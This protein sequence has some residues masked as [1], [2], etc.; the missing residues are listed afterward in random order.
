MIK[1]IIFVALSAGLIALANAQPRPLPFGNYF[2]SCFRVE[3]I[4]PTSITAYCQKISRKLDDPGKFVYSVLEVL[5]N[6]Q[7][8]E[9][10]EN[11]DGALT[12]TGG[13]GF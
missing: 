6:G 1:R 5:K 8:C 2:D 9:Y 10:V 13:F 12:C 4:T 7:R 11:I 3:W